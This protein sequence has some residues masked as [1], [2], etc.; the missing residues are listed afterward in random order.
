MSSS[1]PLALVT[2]ASSGIGMSYARRLLA[3]GYDVIAVGRRKARL[4]S[5][6]A[7]FPQRRVQVE[8]ADLSTLA[9]VQGLAEIC[10]REPITLLVNN[11]GV[12]HYMGF[13]QLPAEQACELL[14]VKVLAPTLLAHAV[15]PGMIASKQG[16][17]VNVAGM[18]AF[19]ATAPLGQAPGRATY[20]AS[21]SHLV[22]LTLALHEEFAHTGMAFQVLCPGVVATEFHERQGMDLSAFPRMSADDVVTASLN[23]LRLQEV[24]CAPGVEDNRLL[25]CALQASLAAFQGQSPALASRYR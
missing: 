20:V 9:G 16:T 6:A 2:G 17:I 15:L 24:V 22:S 25:D 8:V 14:H 12:S 3:D 5:L 18:L 10:R 19:G 4:E 13:T 11:A 1:T 21:L 7:E 23:A